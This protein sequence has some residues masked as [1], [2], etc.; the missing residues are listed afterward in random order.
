MNFFASRTK[1]LCTA[2]LFWASAAQAQIVIGQS[3]GFTGPVS[4]GVAELTEGAKLYLASVNRRGGINGEK[5]ELV[6][7]D[8][9]FKP[10]RT[11]DNARILVEKRK[12]VALFLLRGTPHTEAALPVATAARVPIVA[13]ST[14]AT[15]LH[16]PVNPWVFNVRTLYRLEA[17]QVIRQLHATGLSRIGIVRVDD[18]FG[19]DVEVGALAGLKQIGVEPQFVQKFDRVK[20]DFSNVAATTKETRAQ[21]V[22]IVGAAKAVVDAVAAI[23]TA[24]P[25]TRVVTISN[26][27][28]KGF[29][30]L[31]GS[32]ARGVMVSQVFP[33]AR[34]GTTRF[35]R[36]ALA[37]AEEVGFKGELTPAN[38]EGYAAARVLVAALRKAAKPIT[39]E[40]LQ[41][42]LNE[43]G[44]FD[45]GGL[46]M[47]F[48][49]KDHTGLS[50]VEMS[51]IDD[52]GQFLR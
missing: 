51:I 16:D 40:S 30:D 39:G 46:P 8:D 44:T 22:L 36:E 2:L 9:N 4:D 50:F 3:A 28:S 7:L 13:P 15:L 31:L 17:E 41:R 38:L 19:A 25:S 18:S 48:S 37:I 47:D 43:L 26:N 1:C 34:M 49:S 27:A 10:A 42:A 20:W 23:K 24:S 14:G 6:S 32:N 5:V 35:A 21:A 11:A 45:L 33:K 52:R 29:V 12:A